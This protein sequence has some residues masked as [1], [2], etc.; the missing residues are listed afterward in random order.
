MLYSFPANSINQ[1]DPDSLVVGA[2]GVLYGATQSGGSASLGSVYSLTPPAS[3]G[4]DWTYTDIYD[5]MG[6][7]DQRVPAALAIGAGGVLYGPST[8]GGAGVCNLGLGCGTVFSLTPPDSPDG[9]WTETVLYSFAGKNDGAYPYGNVLIGRGG[10]IYG[11][12]IGGDSAS[13]QVYSL[14]PPASPGGAWTKTLL[15]HF[16]SNSTSGDY[17]NGLAMGADGVLYGTTA[18]GGTKFEGTVFQ[19]KP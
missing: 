1:P 2:G 6:N 9:A 10:V 17:P 8:V 19:L 18:G 15:H 5:S 16:P 13:G 7:G 11:S 12:T 3:P 4:G 14:S